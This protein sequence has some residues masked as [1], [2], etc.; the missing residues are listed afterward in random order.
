MKEK[1]NILLSISYNWVV[2]VFIYLCKNVHKQMDQRMD[3]NKGPPSFLSQL[4]QR[5]ASDVRK[6]Y[7]PHKYRVILP[8]LLLPYSNSL[9]FLNFYT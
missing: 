9:S 2:L 3:Q 5:A 6:E 4:Q 7:K 8:L 1:K